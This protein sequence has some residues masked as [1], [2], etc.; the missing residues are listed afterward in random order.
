[1][2]IVWK[3]V[4]D[5]ILKSLLSNLRF[6]VL[7]LLVMGTTAGQTL[8]NAQFPKVR[9]KG[10]FMCTSRLWHLTPASAA[11]GSASAERGS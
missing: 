7:T 8:A 5:L 3:R 6:C 4:H 1:V 11:R 2:L 9:V 10:L